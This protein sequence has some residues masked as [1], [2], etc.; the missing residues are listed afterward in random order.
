MNSAEIKEI[1]EK[2]LQMLFEYSKYISAN[3]CCDAGELSELSVAMLQ[4]SAV[5]TGLDREAFTPLP[6]VR[7]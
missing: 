5:L 4:I 1:L 2:Q 6:Q 7:G 3:G